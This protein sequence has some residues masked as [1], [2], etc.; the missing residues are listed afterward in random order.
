[1]AGDS[2]V[3]AGRVREF[4]RGLPDF[5]TPRGRPRQIWGAKSG[6]I[7]GVFFAAFFT[8]F[9]HDTC[10]EARFMEKLY[11]ACELGPRTSRIMLGALEHNTLKLGELLRFDTPVLRDKKTLQWNIP[12]MFQQILRSLIEIGAQDT[13]IE[14][15]SCHSWGGDYLLFDRTETLLSP[16]FHHLDPR[17][18]KSWETVL[19]KITPQTIYEETGCP[20]DKRSTLFQLGAEA[21][22][23]LKQSQVLLPFADAFNHLLGGMACAEMSL[24]SATRLFTPVSKTWSRRL[25]ADLRLPQNLLPVIVPGGTRL[26]ELKPEIARQTHLEGAQIIATSSH[27]LAAALA[28]LPL[29]HGDEWA[30][31]RIGAESLIG[32][33]V[34]DPIITP[35]TQALGYNNETCLGGATNLYRRVIG[36]SILDECRRHWLEQDRELCDEVL[37]HLA[38]TSPAFEAFIDPADPRFAAPG[39]MPLKIQAFCRETGQE[40]PRKPGQIIRCILES[41]ALHYRKTFRELELLTGR[42]FAR[43]YLF[44]AGEN[45]LLNHFIVNALQVPAI[46]A[47]PD[48]APIG[49]VIVQALTLRH[50]ASLDAAH[51]ILRSSYKI[52]AI[53]PHQVN[54]EPAAERLAELTT[55]NATVAA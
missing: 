34:G 6:A 31:I 10:I 26:G 19:E 25:S 24:A 44:G 49:N 50:I 18:D 4:A 30:Y 23:R 17:T 35:G 11:I 40:V 52:Q 21:P 9:G 51:E 28:S 5:R 54:W 15:I 1:M 3:D 45:N 47:S 39:D 20:A 53:I 48:A 32:T 8:R 16:V 12:D 33:Q 14:G 29:N 41:L 38:T 36:L 2:S 22:K 27:E 7:S 55:A 46:I 42:K 43:I 37:M 13:N